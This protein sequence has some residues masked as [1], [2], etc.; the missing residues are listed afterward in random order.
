VKC[1][2]QTKAT[3]QKRLVQAGKIALKGRDNMWAV[4]ERM[5]R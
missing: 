1:R 3:V 2:R 5:G 4:M